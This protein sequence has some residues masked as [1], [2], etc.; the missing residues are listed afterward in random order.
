MKDVKAS[1]EM[2]E[3]SMCMAKLEPS[4]FLGLCKLLCV[5]VFDNDNKDENGKPL[6]RKGEDIAVDCI[7]KFSQLNRA[8]RREIMAILR[9]IGKK[10]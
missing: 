9:P 8:K 1:K 10:R 2:I 4:E 6:P 3:F 5:Y 7:D